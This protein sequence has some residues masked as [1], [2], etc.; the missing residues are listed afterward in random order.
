MI[1][2]EVD[3]ERQVALRHRRLRSGRCCVHE[4]RL[5]GYDDDNDGNCGNCG[6]DDVAGYDNDNCARDDNDDGSRGDH[7]DRIVASGSG[8]DDAVVG[9]SGCGDHGGW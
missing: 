1:T 6:N 4:Q 8:G 5:G 3:R 9:C 7:H 2:E